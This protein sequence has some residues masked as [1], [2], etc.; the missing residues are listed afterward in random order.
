MMSML[1]N[2][3]S[4]PSSSLIQSKISGNIVFILLSPLS[5]F[6]FFFAYVLASIIRGVA[7]GIGVFLV[8]MFFYEISFAKPLWIFTFAILSTAVLGTLGLLAGIY[9][10]KFDHI[11]ACTNFLIVPATFLAGVFYSVYSLPP[12]WLNVSR[13]NPFFYMIDGFRYGFFGQ[14][15][16]SPYSSLV[17][18]TIFFSILTWLCIFLLKIGYKLRQ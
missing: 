8:T 3:F 13:V 12:F 11:M 16:V 15:D 4:N 18:V 6:E 7:V 10:E 2:A 17:I 14:S 5:Y 1:Q 9:A